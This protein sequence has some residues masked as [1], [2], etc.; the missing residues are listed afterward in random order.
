M[1]QPYTFAITHLLFI[2]KGVRE[3]FTFRTS[4]HFTQKL[5]KSMSC[6]R[7]DRRQNARGVTQAYKNPRSAAPTVFICLVE[8][9]HTSLR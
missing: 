7:T 6:Q 5:Q 1:Q 8:R 9:H 4:Q 3:C 2:F